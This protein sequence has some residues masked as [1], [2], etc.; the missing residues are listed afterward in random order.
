MA[1]QAAS[2]VEE[3]GHVGLGR[4]LGGRAGGRRGQPSS[5]RWTWAGRAKGASR[6]AIRHSPGMSVWISAP[7]RD[8]SCL[9]DDAQDVAVLLVGQAEDE[10]GVELAEQL[11]VEQLGL[12]GDGDRPTLNL[13]PSRATRGNTLDSRSWSADS[14]RCASSSTTRP[15][16]ALVRAR[17]RRGRRWPPSSTRRV[18]NEAT[19]TSS[20]EPRPLASTSTTLPSS[21]SATTAPPTD[22]PGSARHAGQA[23]RCGGPAGARPAAC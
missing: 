11:V 6:L 15:R 5:Y 17:G 18:R 14:T 22:T 9:E 12:L 20:V 23:R 7:R 10:E 19:S 13:R 2:S 8:R 1:D 3:R 16:A 4:P 21:R